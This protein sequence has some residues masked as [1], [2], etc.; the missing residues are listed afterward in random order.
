VERLL[1]H[2]DRIGDLISIARRKAKSL[3]QIAELAETHKRSVPGKPEIIPD[4]TVEVALRNLFDYTFLA[5]SD[6]ANLRLVRAHSFPGQIT[7]LD[8]G[9]TVH[10]VV[11]DALNKLRPG[12]TDPQY[13]PPREWYPYLILRSAYLEETPNRNNYA[14]IIYL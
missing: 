14:A 13:P 3:N 10:A 11:L 1:D 6:L 5:D 7:S 2:F 8:R 9:K 12:P 4:E